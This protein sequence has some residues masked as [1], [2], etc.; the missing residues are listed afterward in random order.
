MQI[1]SYAILLDDHAELSPKA[2]DIIEH[3]SVTL[4]MEAA[5]E[6]VY[7]LQKIYNV[8]RQYIQRQLSGLVDQQL[9]FVEKP[10]VFLKALECYCSTTFDFVDTLLW[11]YH[12]IEQ[13]DVLTFDKKL[14]K[15]IE[16]TDTKDPNTET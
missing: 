3:Q 1:L 8:D 2:A 16:R 14:R 5:C 10:D 11:G 7:V 6:V 9:V 13:Y 12:V 15:F 4:P